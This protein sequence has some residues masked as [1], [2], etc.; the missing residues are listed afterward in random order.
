MSLQ[1]EK[2]DT[3]ISIQKK[4]T[5]FSWALFTI[6]PFD[7]RT[8]N[9]SIYFLFIVLIFTFNGIFY[10]NQMIVNHF[11]SDIFK[12]GLYALFP[13]VTV[14]YLFM[15]AF[16]FY[17][18]FETIFSDVSDRETQ[19]YMIKKTLHRVKRKVI[20]NYDNVFCV[21]NTV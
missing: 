11:Q 5:N 4:R 2:S 12:R 15:N 17:P 13:S 14:Y 19:I 9:C 21:F 7:M 3:S 16:S 1:R 18:M 8:V 20:N 6:S 10:S